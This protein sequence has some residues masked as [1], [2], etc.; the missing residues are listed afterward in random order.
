[1]RAQITQDIKE[2]LLSSAF[3]YLVKNGLENTSI[4][5]LCKAM[6]ISTGSLYYWFDGKDDIYINAAQ[7]GLAQTA[8]KLFDFAFANLHDLKSLFDNFIP[9]IDDCKKEMRF[10]YQ[11]AT[12]PVYGDRMRQKADDLEGDYTR[13]IEQLSGVLAGS[14]EE[15]APIVFMAISAVL[16]YVVWEDKAVTEMQF[17]YL[18]KLMESQSKRLQEKQ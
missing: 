13:Y 9:V 2:E 18:Y 8:Q 14:P 4:R 11:M 6:G 16:D 10:I 17:A 7:F 5:D 12:S 15:W 1:M 3:R